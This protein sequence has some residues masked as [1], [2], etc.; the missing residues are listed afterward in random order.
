MCD[1]RDVGHD[2][3][4]C[5]PGAGAHAK[6]PDMPLRGMGGEPAAIRPYAVGTSIIR[7]AYH[8]VYA[9]MGPRWDRAMRS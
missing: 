8:L 2:Q 7:A 4:W 5:V 3:P 6:A 1:A 9:S